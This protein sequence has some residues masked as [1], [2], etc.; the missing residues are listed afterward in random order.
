MLFN[1]DFMLLH[2]PKT[3]GKSVTVWFCKNMSKPIH[4]IISKGQH[5]EIGMGP[6]DGVH[7]E[8]SGSHDNLRKAQGILSTYDQKLEDL[9][10]ILV[11]V[12]NP[13]DL[14]VSN[15]FFLR[16]SYERNANV[17]ERPNFK[18]AAESSFSEFCAKTDVADFRGWVELVDGPPSV[19]VELIRFESLAQS[20]TDFSKKYG[21][22]E[23]HPL[24]HLNASKREKDTAAMYDAE[25]QKHVA[26]KMAAMFEIGGY[27][28]ELP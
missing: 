10:A 18:L 2:Y 21:V 5:K 15:Y 7:L 13:Y 23:A 27:S 8:T 24:P 12:R 19:P 26:T 1:T 17:R 22:E 9:K 6:E 16:Q 20:L 28:T 25:S 4:G 14:M 11:P 3:A